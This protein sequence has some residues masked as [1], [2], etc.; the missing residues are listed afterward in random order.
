MAVETSLGFEYARAV[1]D[2]LLVSEMT[3]FNHEEKEKIK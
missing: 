2:M 3:T 1:A